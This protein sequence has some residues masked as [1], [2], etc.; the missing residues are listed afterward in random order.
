LLPQTPRHE[1]KLTGW[2]LKNILAEL[3]ALLAKTEK[4][5]ID[6]GKKTE[7]AKKQSEKDGSKKEKLDRQ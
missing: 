2:A 4:K 3:P 7:D 5:I 6:L 1:S